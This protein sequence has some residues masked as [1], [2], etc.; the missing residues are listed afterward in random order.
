[1]KSKIKDL[2]NLLKEV[3]LEKQELKQDYEEKLDNLK[4]DFKKQVTAFLS[5]QNKYDEALAL[6]VQSFELQY[7]AMQKELDAKD[8]LLDAKDKLLDAKDKLLEA[9]DEELAIL[10]SATF[11]RL[12][13]LSFRGG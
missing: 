4:S 8:K 3:T 10:R 1:M 12:T 6:H 9:K 11:Q 13:D 5:V 7:E 2:N